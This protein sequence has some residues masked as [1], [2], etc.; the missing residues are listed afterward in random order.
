MK[1]K[2]KISFGMIVLNGEP[3]I[4]YNLRALYPF[5]HEIIVV[6]GATH[7]AS[8]IATQDG[9]SID[10]TL[11]TLQRFKIEED[12]ED[13]IT[14]V[15]AEKE[16]HSSGFW[17]G[18]KDEQSQAYASRVSGDYLWQ[19]DSDEF[20]LKED[21]EKIIGILHTN[22]SISGI[23]FKTITFFGNINYV[24]NGYYLLSGAGSYRRLFKW[25]PGYRY[26]THRPPTV[27]DEKKNDLYSKNWVH[28]HDNKLKGCALLHYSLVFPQQV[29]FKA[30]YYNSY[31]PYNYQPLFWFKK[32]YIELQWSFRY[33]NV[34][35]Y[36]SWLE[37]YDGHT[38]LAVKQMIE[39]IQSNC[40]VV[41]TRKNSDI[42][43]L[44]NSYLYKT[45]R[46]FWKTICT[47]SL[48]GWPIRRYLVRLLKRLL[49][50]TK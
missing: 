48:I 19:I 47:I 9:H 21:M 37:R 38:P 4:R 7:F 2:P 39:D 32:S 49:C 41:A 3:F 33:H 40:V 50:L 28:A 26:I 45:Q 44:L 31:K 12:P 6:E 35:M 17:P 23:S 15:T 5:A 24:V 46:I 43:E 18:E 42:E 29:K 20:Y 25:Q 34:Y 22:Q 14:I 1:D 16:G 30:M 27:L 36:R 13:K 8:K 11:D 10:G